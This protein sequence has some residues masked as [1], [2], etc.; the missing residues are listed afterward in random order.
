M[1]LSAPPDR[2]RLVLPLRVEGNYVRDADGAYL[3]GVTKVGT[4]LY[5]GREDPKAFLA[6]LVEAVNR[7]EK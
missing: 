3:L 5:L 7:G 6:A 1:V 4:L 2:R